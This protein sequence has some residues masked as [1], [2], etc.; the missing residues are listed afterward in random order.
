MIR[1][2]RLINNQKRIEFNEIVNGKN[3]TFK[4]IVE[5]IEGDD[6]APLMTELDEELD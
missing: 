1:E 5:D 4:T 3:R 6:A 2:Q